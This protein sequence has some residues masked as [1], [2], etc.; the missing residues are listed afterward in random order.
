MCPHERAL[1][2]ME[3]LVVAG[4]CITQVLI[5]VGHLTYRSDVY[6][7]DG[8]TPVEVCLKMFYLQT[9]YA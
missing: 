6:L 1:Q 2:F 7:S 4:D 3:E 5:L 8:V 9:C